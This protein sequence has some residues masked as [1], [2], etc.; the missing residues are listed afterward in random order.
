MAVGDKMS[1]IAI[2][3]IGTGNLGYPRTLVANVIYEEAIE[4]S[5]RNPT[6]SLK[7][8]RIVLF[9]Q[10]HRTIKVPFE[11]LWQIRYIT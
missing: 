9:D 8:I 4:F 7:E 6:S 5:Q 1:T 3:A 10:D 11:A 2:P